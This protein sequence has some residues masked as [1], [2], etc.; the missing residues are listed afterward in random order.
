M[1]DM[2]S[3]SRRFR[4]NLI[5]LQRPTLAFLPVLLGMVVVILIGGYCFQTLYTARQL[6]YMQRST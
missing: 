1:P 2:R 3:R 4:A 6:S 5:F